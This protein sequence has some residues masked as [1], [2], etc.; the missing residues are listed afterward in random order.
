MLGEKQFRKVY[1]KFND[2]ED[3]AIKSESSDDDNYK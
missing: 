3:D 1:A 2:I